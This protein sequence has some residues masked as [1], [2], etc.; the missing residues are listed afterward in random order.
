MDWISLLAIFFSLILIALLYGIEVAY[1]STNRLSFE[2]KKKQKSVSGKTW[3][4]FSENPTRFVGT[5]IVGANI[6]LVIYGLLIGDM[7]FPV[8]N[9][10]K[11]MLEQYKQTSS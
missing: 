1:A 10:I 3:T 7:L 5:V 6:L 2:L 9:W 11:K 4:K 8:W